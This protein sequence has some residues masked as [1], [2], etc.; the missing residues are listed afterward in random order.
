MILSLLFVIA[1]AFAGLVLTYLVADDKSLLWRLAAGNIVGAAFW[2]MAIFA[3]GFIGGFNTVTV[4]VS[5]LLTLL[6]VT[7][8]LRPNIRKRFDRDVDRAKGKLQGA[9]ST[10]F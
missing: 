8:L 6:P 9:S 1:P 5:L 10:K 4:A 2:G 3:V 7:L